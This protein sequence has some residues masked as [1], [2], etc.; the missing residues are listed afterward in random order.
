MQGSNRYGRSALCVRRAKIRPLHYV[1][2]CKLIHCIIRCSYLQWP[3]LLMIN[4]FLILDNENREYSAYSGELSPARPDGQLQITLPGRAGCRPIII[5]PHPLNTF[6]I[7]WSRHCP[8]IV[9]VVLSPW[10][11]PPTLSISHQTLSLSHQCVSLLAS[12]AALGSAA[13][14][15]HQAAPRSLLSSDSRTG[16][17]V[18]HA[19]MQQL[20]HAEP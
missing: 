13:R 17:A 2:H 18:S 5:T 14:G 19:D 11:S 16:P 15:S 8:I 1:Q 9:T 12:K 7:P 6:L 10:P 20:L 4:G 3:R